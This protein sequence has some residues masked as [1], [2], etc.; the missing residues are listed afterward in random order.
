VVDGTSRSMGYKNVFPRDREFGWEDIKHFL[1]SQYLLM[2]SVF[3]R[4]KLLQGMDMKLPEHTFYVDNIFVYVPL[5]QVKTMRYFDRDAYH[6][7]IGREDQSVNESVMLSRIDQQL[8]ITR[9]MVDSV[10]VSELSEQPKLQRYMY[11]Y[12]SMMYCICSVFLRMEKTDENE[13]KRADIWAY[14]KE[15][16]PKMYAPV[17]ANKLNTLTNLPSGLGRQ[18]ALKGYRVSQ[19][20]FKFN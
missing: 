16:A 12:L 20:L 15:H 4:T 5:P 8:R 3:Y 9:I 14:L 13:Q 11:N 6:Y 18:L 19:K 10:D 2:H 1:P 7:Y 17:R